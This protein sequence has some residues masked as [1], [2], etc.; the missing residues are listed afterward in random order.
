MVRSHLSHV[1]GTERE[2]SNYKETSGGSREGSV[3]G[4]RVWTSASAADHGVVQGACP[5]SA[6]PKPP[7]SDSESDDS[8]EP[9]VEEK[10]GSRE[11][12][13]AGGGVRQVGG[14]ESSTGREP[15]PRAIP[16]FTGIRRQRPASPDDWREV[17]RF[18]LERLESLL[19]HL[20]DMEQATK[21]QLQEYCDTMG[22]YIREYE[23]KI[24]EYEDCIQASRA[25]LEQY[26]ENE[27]TLEKIHR[28]EEE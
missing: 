18:T 21:E 13:Q 14:G 10:R 17:D 15:P 12:Q 2:Q 4:R 19:A 5:K 6:P 1:F 27:E 3:A 25:K 24:A 22:A 11:V 26:K 23:A 16:N 28:G 8:K 20:V 7:N 9:F